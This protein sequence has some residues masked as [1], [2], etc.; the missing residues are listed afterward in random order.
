MAFRSIYFAGD[1]GYAPF[2]TD[3]RERLGCPHMALLPIGAYAPRWFMRDAHMD[4]ADA[5]RCHLELG[6]HRSL[7]I[8][9]G[10]WQLTDEGIDSPIQDLAIARDVNGVSKDAFEAANFGQTIRL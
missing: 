6:A 1:T 5:V 7:G 10:T 2:F 4:P 3:I 9:F 8:H